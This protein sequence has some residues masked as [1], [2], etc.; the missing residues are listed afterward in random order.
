MRIMLTIESRDFYTKNCLSTINF[1][2]VPK[3]PKVQVSF[4]YDVCLSKVPLTNFEDLNDNFFSL[5]LNWFQPQ[6]WVT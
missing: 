5:R 1:I 6:I 4:I 2:N 3:C